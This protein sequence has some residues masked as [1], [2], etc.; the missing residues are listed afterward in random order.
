LFSNLPLRGGTIR[1]R[2]LPALEAEWA[3][4]LDAWGNLSERKMESGLTNKGLRV[5][6]EPL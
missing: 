6:L 2:S 5:K 1:A 4:P 3:E